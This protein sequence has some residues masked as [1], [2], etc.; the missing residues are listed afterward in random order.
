MIETVNGVTRQLTQR[1]TTDSDCQLSETSP[2]ESADLSVLREGEY[3]KC[4][5]RCLVARSSAKRS[6]RDRGRRG[7]HPKQSSTSLESVQT[8]MDVM[9]DEAQF[10]SNVT[11]QQR[12]KQ[13][14]LSSALVTTDALA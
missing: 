2:S 3:L 13:S 4:V 12:T 14:I 9:F 1:R 7:L 6:T 10:L 5:L 8:L 11:E